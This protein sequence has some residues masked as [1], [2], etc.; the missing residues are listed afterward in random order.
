MSFA[1]PILL[2]FLLAVPL[3]VAGYLWLEGRH[4]QRAARWATPALLPNI[5]ERPPS[6]R[7]HLPTALLL[8]GVALLLVGFARPRTRISVKRQEATVVLVLDVSGSMASKDV[9]PTRLGAARE[10]ALRYVDK[11][12]HGYRMALVTFSDHTAVSVPAT[13][14]RN[15]IRAAIS[16]T[17]TGPQGTALADAVTRAV[18]VGL[19]VKGQATN[20]RPPAVVVLFS[21]GGQTAGRVTPK[22]AAAKARK[23]KIPVSAVAVGTP[24]GIVRQ[25]LRGGF[26]ERFQ[27][28]VQP[29][30][31]RTI[32]QGSGGR[33]QRLA[34]IDVKATY[35]AL[36]SRLGKKNKTVEVTSAAAGGGIALMIAGALLSGL[37][38]RRLP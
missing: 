38:F 4:E 15:A 18:D 30:V 28:P 31:L 12:P 16:K 6:W 20:R 37:W 5:V 7:R 27:V 9:R 10:A 19:S 29:A 22:Q 2:V 24:D 26:F 17:K 36:G 1:A 8:A 21:D 13:H 23:S 32:A 34:D 14:D 35:R 25:P 11:V 3:A 33:F